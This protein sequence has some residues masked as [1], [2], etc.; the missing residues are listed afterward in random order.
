LDFSA[1][2]TSLWN[3]IIQFGILAGSMLAANAL[4]RKIIFIRKAMVPTAV[5]AGFFGSL[6]KISQ[7]LAC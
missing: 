1:A 4:R 5:L 7:Y 3:V 2:N 6:Y